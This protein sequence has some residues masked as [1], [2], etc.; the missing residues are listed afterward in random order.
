[1][2]CN[3][4]EHSLHFISM[5]SENEHYIEND[6]CKVKVRAARY[7]SFVCDKCGLFKRVPLVE[8]KVLEEAV[9]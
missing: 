9:K 5:D 8:E 4:G 6:V 1:M 3:E 2:V 7:I